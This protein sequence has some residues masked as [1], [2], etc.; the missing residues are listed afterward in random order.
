MLGFHP[1]N[2][3]RR[4]NKKIEGQPYKDIIE[5]LIIRLLLLF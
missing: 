4:L 1:D 5:H 2:N 3:A